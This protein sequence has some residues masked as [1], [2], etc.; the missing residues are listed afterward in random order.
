ME[1]TLAAKEVI[2]LR[3]LL[4]DFRQPPRNDTPT[5]INIDNLGA[6]EMAKNDIYHS[7]SKHIDIQWHWIRERVAD[8]FI[9]LHPVPSYDNVADGFT[10]SLP[11][12]RFAKFRQD[13]GLRRLGA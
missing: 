10:K 4:I 13:I 7:R 1:Y 12:E 5:I 3:R 8:G 9:W 11:P 2:W 6:R